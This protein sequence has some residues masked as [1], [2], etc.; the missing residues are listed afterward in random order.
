MKCPQ[1]STSCLTEPAWYG[2]GGR[3]MFPFRLVPFHFYPRLLVLEAGVG[4]ATSA[5]NSGAIVLE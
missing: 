5:K 4:L 1:G 3:E 2:V